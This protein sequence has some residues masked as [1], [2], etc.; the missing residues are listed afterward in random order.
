MERGEIEFNTEKTSKHAIELS[1]ICF[2]NTVPDPENRTVILSW[3]ANVRDVYLSLLHTLR[4]IAQIC[5]SCVLCSLAAQAWERLEVRGLGEEASII[6][7]AGSGWERHSFFEW[8][9]K[10]VV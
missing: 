10:K 7:R 6:N 1:D 8:P 5:L 4:P 3:V 9:N 2:R